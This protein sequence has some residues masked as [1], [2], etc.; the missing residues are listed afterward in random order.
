MTRT[1]TYSS[2]ALV[3]FLALGATAACSKKQSTD[4]G[5][6]TVPVERRD[7][8][9]TAQATGTVEPVDTVAVKSQAQ[10]LIVAMPVEVGSQVKAGDLIAQLDTRTLTNDYE[11]AVAAEKA[12]VAALNV[13]NADLQRENALYAQKVVTATEH[14]QAVV[15]AANAQSALIAAQTNLKTAQQNLEYAT[16]RAQVGGTVISKNASVGTVAS[17]AL[18]NVGG[19]STIVT[20]ADLRHVRMRALVNETDVGN[21]HPG[22][23]VTVTV[24]AFPN[25]QFAGVVE[26]VEPQ[27]VVQQSVTMFPVLVSL[28]NADLA[29]LPGMNG[30]VSIV[31]QQAQGVLA[32]PNDAVRSMKDAMTIAPALGIPAESLQAELRASAT[33][34]ASSGGSTGANGG[35]GGPNASGGFG[36]RG[37]NAIT[38]DSLTCKRVTAKMDSAPGLRNQLDSLRRAMFSGTG[39]TASIR[40]TMQAAYKRAHLN[41]DT[42]R[43]CMRQARAGGGGFGGGGGA[44]SAGGAGGFGGAAGGAGGRGGNAQIVFVKAGTSWQPRRVRLGVSDF[45]YSQVLSGLQQGDQVAL[46]GTVALQAA[47]DRS[48]ARARAITNT[49]FGSSSNSTSTS[50]PGGGGGGGRGGP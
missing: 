5:I 43:A 16:I 44:N 12:A 39:D 49:G 23:P 40:T 3:A 25:R 22:M 32:V 29:L 50:R 37:G 1:S 2:R 15:T 7:I 11:R 18:S 10:G 48:S 42:V 35:R 33:R 19:G 4:T 6:Q 9:V 26:K 41:A 46:V 30:E 14:E 31:T 24:D 45:D 21:V 34:M 8:V 38:V 13:A 36:G 17:S 27:A 28:E 47:R 20:L